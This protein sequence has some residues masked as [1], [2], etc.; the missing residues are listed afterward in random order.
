MIKIGCPGELPFWVMRLVFSSSHFWCFLYGITLCLEFDL[1]TLL[2]N[3]T[4]RSQLSK[5]LKND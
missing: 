3:K 4:F 2:N 5:N 1:T